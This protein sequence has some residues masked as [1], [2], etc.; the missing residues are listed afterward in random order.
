MITKLMQ[1]TT[2][3]NRKAGV[4]E[5]NFRGKEGRICW[6]ASG[7]STSAR[8]TI[9]GRIPSPTGDNI[10][11]P[12]GDTADVNVWHEIYRSGSTTI[13]SGSSGQVEITHLYPEMWS[14]VQGNSGGIRIRVW[15]AYDG[16]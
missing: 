7:G 1:D 16:E 11:N 8:L 13:A 5:F 6:D 15:L 4:E 3:T 12:T 14:R 9:Y 2:D 10:V